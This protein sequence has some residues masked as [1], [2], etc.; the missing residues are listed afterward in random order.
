MPEAA[1]RSLIMPLH[2]TRVM[3]VLGDQDALATYYRDT[4]GPSTV[5][6]HADDV[7]RPEIVSAWQRAGHRIVMAGQR[8]DPEFLGRI[9]RLVASHRR[10]VS[11]RLMTLDHV[12]RVAGSR[13]RRPTGT[14]EPGRWGQRGPGTGSSEPG[15][16]STASAWTVRQ[17]ATAVARMET[18]WDS[19]PAPPTALTRG[20]AK[21]GP[22]ARGPG[23]RLLDGRAPA[24]GAQTSWAS[25]SGQRGRPREAQG[26]SPLHFL[27]HPMSHLP[28]PLPRRVP[29]LDPLPE[30]FAVPDLGVVR[31]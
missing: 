17:S 8:H 16:S 13:G 31:R 4:E 6:L 18:G 29:S 1:D 9:L 27:R 24:E 28:K 12:C 10:T 5:C 11:N 3:E 30:P 2:G 25:A 19:G 22:A 7:A 26:L 14:P 21:L 23:P 15:P 20:S